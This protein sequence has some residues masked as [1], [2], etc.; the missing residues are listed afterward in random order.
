VDR[1]AGA[2]IAFVLAHEMAHIRLDHFAPSFPFAVLTS[3]QLEHIVE[4]RQDWEYAADGIAT[5]AIANAGYA[6]SAGL[7]ILERISEF[8]LSSQAM[9]SSSHPNLRDRLTAM[10]SGSITTPLYTEE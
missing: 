9:A 1:A 10:K 4:V 8:E 7:S 6:R 5:D 2:E 3:A